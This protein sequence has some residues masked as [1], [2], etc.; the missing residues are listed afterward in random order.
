MAGVMAD[1]DAALAKVVA[2]ADRNYWEHLRC[3][4]MGVPWGEAA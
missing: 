3:R 1:D 4:L 2:L